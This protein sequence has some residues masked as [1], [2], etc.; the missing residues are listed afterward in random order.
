MS[1]NPLNL[2]VRFILE[3]AALVATGYGGWHATEGVARYPLAFGL[4]LIMA[5]L[6]G[7]FRTP[8][9]P[10][11]PTHPVRAVPGWA[12]LLIEAFVFGGGAWGLFSTGATTLGWLYALVLLVHY[13]LSYDRVL[14]L[15]RH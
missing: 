10:H 14:W 5:F 1:Q 4:P 3:I 12:R 13:A 8:N 6:W 2:A 9:E 7:A 15:L 11:H